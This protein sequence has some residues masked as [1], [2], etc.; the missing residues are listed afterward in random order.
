MNGNKKDVSIPMSAA[1]S[2][3]LLIAVPI[4]VIQIVPFFLLHGYPAIPAS[5]NMTLYALAL[6]LGILE[7]EL[8]HVFA[9]AL[10]AKKPF[11]ATSNQT[12]SWKIIPPTRAVITYLQSSFVNPH[13]QAGLSASLRARINREK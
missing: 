6:L 4:A 10:F 13:R 9:W 1:T 7:H 2:K 8:I 12:R 11:Y 5:A 3:S